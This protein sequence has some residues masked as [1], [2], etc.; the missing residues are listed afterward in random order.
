MVGV[1][2][3]RVENAIH[4]VH[5][6]CTPIV[7]ARRSERW[8]Y[9][10]TQ[11]YPP[12][13]SKHPARKK[14]GDVHL[15][16]RRSAPARRR[17]ASQSL[18]SSSVPARVG[19]ADG[20]TGWARRWRRL[21]GARA[22]RRG[23]RLWSRRRWR[24][25]RGGLSA[26]GAARRTRENPRPPSRACTRSSGTTRTLASSSAAGRPRRSTSSSRSR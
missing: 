10:A 4:G 15:L 24:R 18:P 21:R 14:R 23:T 7:R 25:W 12:Y 5:C 3:R 26:C 11:S 17:R 13:K 1:L 8:G 22:A 9:A 16:V 6:H 20:S 19:L 2:F